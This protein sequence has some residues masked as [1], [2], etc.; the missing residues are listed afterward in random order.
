M[1]SKHA[2]R[3]CRDGW[4]SRVEQQME[5]EIKEDNHKDATLTVDRAQ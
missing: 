4:I 3:Q 5:K 1:K 2:E